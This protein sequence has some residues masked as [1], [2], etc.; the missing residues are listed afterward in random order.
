MLTEYL[1]DFTAA[2]AITQL[3]AALVSG[4]CLGLVSRLAR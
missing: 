3:V 4:I 2:D 1:T